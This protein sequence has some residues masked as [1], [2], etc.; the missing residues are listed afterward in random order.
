[1]LDQYKKLLQ[2]AVR[3]QSVS[4]SSQYQE[5]IKQMV[6]WYKNLF[7][8]NQFSVKVIEGYDNPIILASYA[9]DPSYKTVLIYGHYDVQPAS[10]DEGWDNEPFELAERDGRLIARGAIDNKGQVL[11][12]LVNVF[13]LL[14]GKNLRYNVKFM[15]EGNEE[16]GSPHLEG[17]IQDN[18]ELLKTDFVMISDGEISGGVPNLEVAFRGGFNSALT[19]SVGTQDLHSGLYGS[20]APNAIH[21]LS[22]VVASLHDSEN[23]IAIPGFYDNVLPVTKEILDNNKTIP[24]SQEEYQRI[25]TRKAMLAQDNYDFYTQTGLLPAIEVSGIQAGYMG[26]GYRNAIP[27]Q[28]SAKI[29]FRLVKNQ[30]AQAVAE[31]FKKHVRAVLPDY[32]DFEFM[33][34][35][36][37]DGVVLNIDNEYVQKAKSILES[38]WGRPAILKYNGGGLPIATYFDRILQVPQVLV[39]FANE[40]C[41]MHGANENFDLAYLEKALRF[42]KTF[43]S[44]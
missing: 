30:K 40:D 32:A 33:M 25:T 27:G 20:A 3:L 7:E 18:Q 21:E 38:V 16:T 26:Q 13:E 12:H 23:K 6:A 4:T 43:L 24:F 35:N 10:K 2:E 39:P 5:Q 44:Q 34:T 9:A 19:I 22:K 8:Q 28:A 29:N 42:S 41:H 31:L 17:F 15:I 36:P 14:K 1:M 37:Y 11:A